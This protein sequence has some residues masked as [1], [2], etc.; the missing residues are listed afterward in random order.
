MDG[1]TFMNE[2]FTENLDLYIKLFIF[3]YADETIIFAESAEG[4]QKALDVFEQYCFEWKLTV[5]VSKTKIVIFSKRKFNKNVTFKLCNEIIEIKDSYV[6]LGLL[7]NYN[8]NFFQA[9]KKLVDQAQKALYALCKKIQNISLPIDLQLKLFDALV[10]PILTYSSE[11]WGFENKNNTEKLHLQF[12]KSSLGMQSTTPN[13]MVYGE[14]GRFPLELRIKLEMVCFWHKL[15]T[16]DK[17]LS[18]KLYKLLWY[19]HEHEGYNFKWFNYVKSVFNNC[20]FCELYNIPGQVDYNYIKSNVRQR[21]QDQF[22]QKW[23]SDINNSSRGD[24]IY[25]L[26][27]SFA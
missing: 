11:I 27:K 21:L 17:K 6:Y 19:M 26:K 5:N 14:L 9:R 20:G 8:G 25:I 7:F 22:I 3:L 1:L 13:F 23:F 2:K 16:N 4:L 15:A 24:F 18:G 10:V 12:C